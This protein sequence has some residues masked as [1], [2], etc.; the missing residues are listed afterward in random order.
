MQLLGVD[1]LAVLKDRRKANPEESEPIHLVVP[2][3][4]TADVLIS[5]ADNLAGVE[6]VLV[7]SS[8]PDRLAL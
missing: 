1:I 2:D 7:A 3:K 8:G 4:A 5:I 6:L